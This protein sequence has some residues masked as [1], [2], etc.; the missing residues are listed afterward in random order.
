MKQFIGRSM[1]W[2]FPHILTVGWCD[3]LAKIS[4]FCARTKGSCLR[5]DFNR[6]N[7]R[8]HDGYKVGLFF[9]AKGI[10]TLLREPE[11]VSTCHV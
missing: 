2:N 3:E 10:A 7:L 8:V 1:M 6:F 4:R 11:F 5:G 9:K